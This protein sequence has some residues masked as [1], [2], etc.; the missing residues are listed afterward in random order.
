MVLPQLKETLLQYHVRDNLRQLRLRYKM[1]PSGLRRHSG[2]S[3]AQ[4]AKLEH[5]KL[6]AGAFAHGAGFSWA[7]IISFPMGEINMLPPWRARRI[8]CVSQEACD[9]EASL[10]I[11]G[12]YR[13]RL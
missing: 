6:S 1:G 13:C 9:L 2:L 4:P 11:P 5:G 3:P 12:L 10:R 7:S 8:A